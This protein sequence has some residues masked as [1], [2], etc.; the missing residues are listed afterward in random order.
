MSNNY[1]SASFNVP[2]TAEE[3]TLFRQCLDVISNESDDDAPAEFRAAFASYGDFLEIFDDADFPELGLD[4]CE[5][6]DEDGDAWLAGHDM[7]V[8]NVANLL[9][10]VCKSALPFAFGYAYHCSKLRVDEFGGG[11]MF[12]T[13]EGVTGTSTHEMVR[14]A[15]AA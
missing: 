8:D 5:L 2:M 1:N 13:E 15:M 9:W 7:A 4:H 11:A 10:A 14:R 6:P 3:S 12:M